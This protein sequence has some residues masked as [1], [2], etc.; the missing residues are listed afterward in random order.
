MARVKDQAARRAEIVDA[1]KRAIATR[2]LTGL[3]LKDVAAECELTAGAVAYYYPDLTQ[4]VREVH[5]DEVDR[6]YWDRR[7]AIEA[8]DD[9]RVKLS[10]TVA[11][12]VPS[13][14]R[15]VDFQVLNELH[16]HAYRDEVHARLMADLFDREVSLYESVLMDGVAAGVFALKA[17]AGMIA[18]N[19]VALEDAYGLHVLGG[20]R[21]GGAEVRD[22]ILAHAAVMVGCDLG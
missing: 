13:S 18:R 15:D 22:M 4:L 9:P 7:R 1:A 21:V 6:F 5:L 11:S 14:A 19:L 16:V 17:P 2:G 12:G 8:V 20:S 10:R 3:R